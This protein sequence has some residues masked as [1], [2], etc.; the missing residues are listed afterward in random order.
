MLLITEITRDSAG[1]EL[2]MYSD[3][4]YDATGRGRMGRRHGGGYHGGGMHGRRRRCVH[5][6]DLHLEVARCKNFLRVLA[7]AIV[8]SQ[9]FSKTFFVDFKKVNQLHF[10]QVNQLVIVKVVIHLPFK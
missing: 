4:D 2:E 1:S 5:T 3:E 9:I 7:G 6:K 10:Y 8:T